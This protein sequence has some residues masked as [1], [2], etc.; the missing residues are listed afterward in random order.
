MQVEILLIQISTT[1][2]IKL[3]ISSYKLDLSQTY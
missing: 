2:E 3:L 1:I